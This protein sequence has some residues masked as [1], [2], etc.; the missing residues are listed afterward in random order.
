M[1]QSQKL[2]S[3][4]LK[5]VF[6]LMEKAYLNHEEP[7]PGS[8]VS[9]AVHK[10]TRTHRKCYQHYDQEQSTNNHSYNTSGGQH[11]T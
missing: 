7:N 4:T 10:D 11:H 8:R 2:R 1:P 9:V 5:L 6:E 3:E